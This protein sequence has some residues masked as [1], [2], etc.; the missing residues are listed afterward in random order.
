MGG[1]VGDKL[2]LKTNACKVFL[3]P[4]TYHE[5]IE[6]PATVHK[7]DTLGDSTISIRCKRF[8]GMPRFVLSYLQASNTADPLDQALAWSNIISALTEA[9][10]KALNYSQVSGVLMHLIPDESLLDYSYEW[11]STVIVDEA[12]KKLFVMSKNKVTCV[13][14]G[15]TALNLGT[16]YGLLFEPYFHVRI[17]ERGYS[18]KCRRLLSPD[19]T[20][21]AATKKRTVLG[22]KTDQLKIFTLNIPKMP[23]FEFNQVNEIM[24]GCYNNTTSQLLTHFALIVEKF[25][26]LPKGK[27]MTSKGTIWNN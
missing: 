8:G 7:F 11:G 2:Y 9:G 24:G 13:M 1:S 27:G 19:N 16:F 10:T 22:V 18:G 21:T 5:T 26:R 15:A 17:S 12:F 20:R 25:I 3:P 14:K 4:W 23:I 6:V